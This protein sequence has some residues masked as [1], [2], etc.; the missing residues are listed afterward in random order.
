MRST[1]ETHDATG[2]RGSGRSVRAKTVGACRSVQALIG[3]QGEGCI[4]IAMA[5]AGLIAV[6]LVIVLLMSPDRL[7][8]PPSFHDGGTF[9]NLPR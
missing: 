1:P 8:T 4:V 9:G 3:K 2:S 7:G 5:A 6:A